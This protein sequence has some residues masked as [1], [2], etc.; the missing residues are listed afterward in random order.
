MIINCDTDRFVHD[1]IEGN[2]YSMLFK[3]LVVVD[4]GCNIGTFSLWIAKC[5]MEI[6]A[7]DIAEENTTNLYKT[8]AD[9]SIDNI[10][11]Y[12]AAIT[13][14]DGRVGVS[15]QGDPGMGGFC[16]TTGDLIPS[17][18][19]STFMDVNDIPYIDVLKLDVEGAEKD[20][21]QC[22]SFPF[23]KISTIVGEWHYTL[24]DIKVPLEAHGFRVSTD[25]QNHFVARR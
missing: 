21:I 12:T 23:T 19:L 8:I 16:V 11:V 9:N 14:F 6:H 24:D 15:R 2:E 7:I 17:F 20:I 18:T 4:V 5:A 1:V 13:G 25:K 22:E 10:Y 3:D